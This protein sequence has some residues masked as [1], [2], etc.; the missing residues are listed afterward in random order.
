MKRLGTACLLLLMVGGLALATGTTE[1]GAA[2]EGQ[3]YPETVDPFGRYETPIT[4]TIAKETNAAIDHP[5]GWSYSENVWYEAIE[6]ELGITLVNKFEAEGGDDYNTRMNLAI[7][8]N[9]LPDILTLPQYN[10]YSRLLN[11]GKLT[12]MTEEYEKFAY[13][14]FKEFYESDGGVMKS[15]GTVDDQ[16]FGFARGGLSYQSPRIVYIRQDWR[17]EL[18]LEPPE[19][20]DDVIEIAEAFKA[21][22]PDNRYGILLNNEISTSGFADMTGIANSMGVY[23]RKWVLNEDGEISYGSIQPG[24]KDVIALYRDFYEQGLVHPEFATID[25]SATAPHLLNSQVGVAVAAPWVITWPLPQLWQTDG[26]NWEVYP[27]LPMEGYADEAL[28]QLDNVERQMYAVSDG[29]DYPEAFVKIMNLQIAKLNDPERAQTEIYHSDDEYTYHQYQPF[30]SAYAPTFLNLDTQVNVTAAIDNG[31]DESYLETPHD[32]N[33]Y[34]P[35]AEYFEAME[36][37]EKPTNT[38]WIRYNQWY[39]DRSVFGA[40][41]DYR[42]DERYMISPAEGVV[43]P[44]MSRLI[45]ALQQVEDEYIIQIVTGNRPL[46]DFDDFVERWH[47]LGGRQILEELNAWYEGR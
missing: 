46:D 47:E 18:G 4:V 14:K 41:N 27:I 21:E 43:T 2:E 3:Q 42:F 1:T 28:V 44:E 20:M 22:D 5:E 25:G 39:G 45:G 7:A 24:M 31:F 35:V 32:R 11:A 23:P 34:P 30:Y 40:L 12:N 33:Q 15:W 6:D 16:I 36:A 10:M 9:D 13:P 29:F 37:D 26:V 17:E 8:S 38:Q 19:T